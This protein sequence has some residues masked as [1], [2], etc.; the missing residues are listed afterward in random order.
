MCR[1]IGELID[2]IVFNFFKLRVNI[3]RAIQ[4][5]CFSSVFCFALVILLFF[6]MRQSDV[7]VVLD[8]TAMFAMAVG[9]ITYINIIIGFWNSKRLRIKTQ[10]TCI[11]A[12]IWIHTE[13]I[14]IIGFNF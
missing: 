12:E 8:P 11:W 14:I 5:V 9:S 4:T 7:I 13:F 3:R 10:A 6:L 2:N 1:L